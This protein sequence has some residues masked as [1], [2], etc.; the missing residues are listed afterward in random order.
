MSAKSIRYLVAALCITSPIE[1]LAQAAAVG[2]EVAA[3]YSVRSDVVYHTGSGQELTLDLYLPQETDAPAPVLIYYHGGGWVVS[4]RQESSLLILPYLE[5]GFAV[6]NVSYRLAETALAPAAVVDALC[7]LRWVSRGAA[8]FGG[9]PNRIVVTG[10]SAGGHLALIVAMLPEDTPFA[11]E[12]AVFPELL[13]N[14]LAP[15]RPAAVV[16]WYGIADVADLLEEPRRQLYAEQWIGG[17]LGGMEIARSVSPLQYVRGGLPPIVTIHGDAD[18]FVPYEHAVRL[19]DAL[20]AAGS[21]GEL[22]TISGGEHGGFSLQEDMDAYARIW[23][24]LSD[25]GILR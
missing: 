20:D 19:R 11:N 8:D 3:S 4:N 1:A 13:E 14:E 10:H 18:P 21:V 15:A 12:C 6:A 24:F 2:V 7:A 17:Q 22:V 5:K 16:N 9:D 23:S 25:H